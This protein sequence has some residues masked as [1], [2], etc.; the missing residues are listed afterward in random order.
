MLMGE[1]VLALHM[2]NPDQCP[3]KPADL[4]WISNNA[5][6]L[7]DLEGFEP[8][9][10]ETDC[11]KCGGAG[12]VEQVD[13]W[14]A[15]GDC[16]EGD[17]AHATFYATSEKLAE[18]L[19]AN[20]SEES[21]KWHQ[22]FQLHLIDSE[23]LLRREDWVPRKYCTLQLD[24]DPFRVWTKRLPDGRLVRIIHEWFGVRGYDIDSDLD[25]SGK[26]R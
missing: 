17:L 16:E 24:E 25:L 11:E 7:A 14:H 15:C 20:E 4:L 23:V 19:R 13:R 12:I 18:R 8:F 5:Q 6:V 10:D 21:R 22:W 2:T 9:A 3:W 1:T 26:A